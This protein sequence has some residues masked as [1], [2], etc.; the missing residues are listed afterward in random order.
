MEKIVVVLNDFEKIDD[1]LKKAIMLCQKHNS[2]LEVL[3]I[4]ESP[5]FDLPDFFRAKESINDNVIDKDKVEKEIK[6]RIFKF[7]FTKNHA[8]L[9]FDSGIIGRV[10]NQTREDKKALILIAYNKEFIHQLA[11][12]SDL[13]LLIV[14]NSVVDYKK[15]VLPI[16]FSE[17][18]NKCITYANTIFPDS[19]KK[20]LHD[21]RYVDDTSVLDDDNFI[22]A[23]PNPILNAEINEE[24]KKNRLYEFEVLKKET[25][26]EGDFIEESIS[27]EDDLCTYIDMNNFDLTFLCLNKKQFLFS[28]SFC[29]S[30]L[31]KLSTDILIKV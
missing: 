22:M 31:D 19:E 23:A 30:L 27:L 26:F 10:L 12:E 18:T 1:L 16:N 29:L 20:L 6:E 14:K 2:F 9:V 24:F 7:G 3:Y 17:N 8:I 15:I 4:N 5:L 13:P 21:Y 11:K 25:G 28:D